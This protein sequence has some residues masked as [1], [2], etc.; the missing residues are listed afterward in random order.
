MVFQVL[1]RCGRCMQRQVAANPQHRQHVYIQ[2][3]TG[4]SE[5]SSGVT[6]A[7]V[8]EGEGEG[9]GYFTCV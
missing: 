8:G 5:V 1:G 6:R 4:S 9:E 2:S 3:R 7:G